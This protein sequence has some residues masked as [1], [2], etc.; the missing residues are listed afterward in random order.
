[1]DEIE[2]EQEAALDPEEEYKDTA[3][4]AQCGGL[5]TALDWLRGCRS[6]GTGAGADDPTLMP[7]L[8]R[9]LAAC[10]QLKTNRLALVQASDRN[11]PKAVGH[12]VVVAKGSGSVCISSAGVPMPRVGAHGWGRRKYTFP[13]LAPTPTLTGGVHFFDVSHTPLTNSLH[14]PWP[15]GWQQSASL[16]LAHTNLTHLP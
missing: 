9:L 7:L 15:S 16:H 2:E 4:L 3:V 5:R 6:G 14:R 8:L 11:Q 13:A 1:M 10:C 12:S